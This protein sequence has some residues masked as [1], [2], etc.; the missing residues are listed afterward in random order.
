VFPTIE[1]A[2]HIRTG[3]DRKER[4]GMESKGTQRA[5]N[6]SERI[7]G[8]MDQLWDGFSQG[9][10]RSLG[11]GEEK[12]LSS[13]EVSE[14]KSHIVVKAETPGIDP[15]DI[16]ITFTDGL[17]TIEDKN[18]EEKGENYSPIGNNYGALSRSVWLRQDVQSDKIKASFKN[19]V[20]NIKLPKSREAKKK[21]IKIEVERA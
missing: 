3:M 21:E 16:N 14:T 18:K 2:T 10:L 7:R 1:G 19:G 11:Y 20:L 5:M 15:M 12:W 9:R 13:L 17:L 6:K 4:Y 8:G